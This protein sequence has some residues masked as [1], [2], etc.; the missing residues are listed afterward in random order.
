MSAATLSD[1]RVAERNST[2]HAV[3]VSALEPHAAVWKC[4]ADIPLSKRRQAL[5][6]VDCM[7]P[8]VKSRNRSD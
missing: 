5:Q 1:A 8:Y 2:Q 4:L 3:K 6:S 7:L